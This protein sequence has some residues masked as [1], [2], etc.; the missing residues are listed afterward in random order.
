M[1][2][3]KLSTLQPWSRLTAWQGASP[4]KMSVLRE[5]EVVFNAATAADSGL[6]LSDSFT[7]YDP[8]TSLWRTSQA[9]LFSQDLALYSENWPTAGMMRNGRCYQQEPLEPHTSE[10]ESGSLPT[11]RSQMARRPSWPELL[12]RAMGLPVGMDRL[13]TALFLIEKCPLEAGKSVN[14]NYVEYM[15]G[16][17]KMW[18]DLED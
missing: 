5:P 17:P 1:K 12:K 14:P 6:S 9:C 7:H 2:T 15:M 3:C 4:V 13:E 11:P 8:N 16:Y 18:T 10:S